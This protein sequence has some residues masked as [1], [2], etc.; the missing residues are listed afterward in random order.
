MQC[1][2]RNSFGFISPKACRES[3]SPAA[4]ATSLLEVKN[5]I[6]N[7]FRGSNDKDPKEG[8]VAELLEDDDDDKSTKAMRGMMLTMALQMK[9]L[10]E[11][12]KDA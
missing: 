12:L 7:F 11:D 3:T 2:T 1:R 4:D 9:E 5:R 8:M 6:G 10:Q